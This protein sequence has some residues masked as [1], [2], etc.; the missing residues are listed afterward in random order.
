[1]QTSVYH[2]FPATSREHI[3][4]FVSSKHNLKMV[5]FHNAP[6]EKLDKCHDRLILNHFPQTAWEESF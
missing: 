1:M 4:Q 6:I 3:F 2:G 5:I